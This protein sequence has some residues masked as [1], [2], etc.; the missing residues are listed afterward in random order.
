[1]RKLLMSMIFIAFGTLYAND[2]LIY[3]AENKDGKI[4]PQTIE[5]EFKKAGF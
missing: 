2:V 1:M 3:S 4:T 5:D